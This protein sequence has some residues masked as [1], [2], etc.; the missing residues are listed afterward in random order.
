MKK[1]MLVCLVAVSSLATH[2]QTMEPKIQA[3]FVLKFVDNISWPQDRKSIIIGVIGESEVFTELESRLKV[4]NPNGLVIKRITASDVATCDAVF[5]A[6][7][8][9]AV[10]KSVNHAT[11][12]KPVL[13]IS[14]SD[15]SKKGSG[16]SF[17]EESGK[18]AFIINKEAIESA[19][20][21]ISSALLTLG[22]Q[23]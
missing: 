3:L 15:L 20:L 10:I 19:G 17:V 23:A 7:G 6:K 22:K 1:L 18:L 11:S 9:S 2:A 21:K 13:I 4:K 8:E 12:G 5:L 16:I 14:E